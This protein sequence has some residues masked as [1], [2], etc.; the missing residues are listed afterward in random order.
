MVKLAESYLEGIGVEDPQLDVEIL[1][2]LRRPQLLSLCYSPPE[3]LI[4]RDTTKEKRAAC[5]P[6][7]VDEEVYH[8]SS[9][10][11]EPLLHD[12]C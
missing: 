10:D 8:A 6:A 9:V 7:M 11:E 4:D 12:G 3:P 2:Y 5:E 1:L